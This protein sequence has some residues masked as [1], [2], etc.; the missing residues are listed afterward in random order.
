MV[1]PLMLSASGVTLVEEGESRVV[2]AH[3][4]LGQDA[5]SRNF[6]ERGDFSARNFGRLTELERSE[7]WLAT[8]IADLVYHLERMS[9]ARVPVLVVDDPSEVPASAVVIGS[10]A[11]RMGG[12][13][14]ENLEAEESFRLV[15]SGGRVLIAG[16]GEYGAYGA[17]HGIYELLGQ[18]GADWLFP[19]PEGEVIPELSTVVVGEQDL[20][21]APDFNP[22]HVWYGGFTRNQE[23]FLDFYHWTLRQRMQLSQMLV[24]RYRVGGHSWSGIIRMFRD[25]FDANPELF[26]LRRMPDGSLVRRG[27]QIETT[28]PRVIELAIEYIRNV[29]ERNGWEKDREVVIPMGPG[30]GGGM[31]ESPESRAAGVERTSPDSGRP[32]GTDLVVLFLNEILEATEEE[33]PNLH[34]GFF[35]YSWHA[36]FP[37]RYTPHPRVAIEVADLNFS[38]KHGVGD[39]NSRSRTHFRNIMENWG[40][41]HE[42]Q[43]NLIYRY[44]YGYNVANGYLPISMIRIFGEGIPFDR[45]VGTTGMRFNLYPNWE[46]SGANNYIG[47]RLSW[48][49]SL[50]WRELLTEFCQKGYGPAA[51]AMERY[52]LMVADRQ[53][54]AGMEAGA[55]FAYPLIYDLEFVAEMEA[56]LAEAERLAANDLQRERIGFMKIQ[57]QRLRWFLELH[58]LIKDYKFVEALALYTR[59][60]E[61]LWKDKEAN[62]NF[63]AGT[64]ASRFLRVYA[65]QFLEAATKYSTGDYRMIYEVPDRLT[66]ALD[67]DVMGQHL[68]YFLRGINDSYYFTTA[69]YSSTW[70]AQ[71]FGGFRKGAVWYRIPFEVEPSVIESLGEGEGVGLL[72]GGGEGV[73]NIWCNDQF[74]ARVSRYVAHP[75]VIDITDFVEPGKDN[76][77]ALQ[78]NRVGNDDLG[79]G[80]LH[81]PSFIFTGPRVEMDERSQQRPFRVLPGGILEYID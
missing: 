66:T 54:D 24:N 39:T 57:P 80:G 2:I 33:F 23:A 62:H 53:R 21:S 46:V 38:R 67:R 50:D 59:M 52:F 51:E 68:G 3:A 7:M 42:E 8:A 6:E 44:Y 61:Q 79:T 60:Q 28:H 29:Y 5:V 69:T 17:S 22:R 64:M 43:G 72:I 58:E 37:M 81:M 71:G 73:I 25:E 63:T 40:R 56:T 55:F 77:I 47:A 35:L 27:P 18:M 31:S 78:L 10:L 74:V 26:A 20:Q 15:T 1:L 36:D 75:H 16:H 30:D 76:L 9:G 12:E 19:G 41:L 65:E 13:V 48:D 45:S 4:P 34:L 14:T 49:S 70:D 11:E 32:D